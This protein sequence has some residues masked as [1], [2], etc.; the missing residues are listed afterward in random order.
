LETRPVRLDPIV[1]C[2]H[3]RKVPTT[4]IVRSTVRRSRG[5]TV[6]GTAGTAAGAFDD[7]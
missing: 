6:T 4:L 7:G 3:P 2:S 5:A 1:T